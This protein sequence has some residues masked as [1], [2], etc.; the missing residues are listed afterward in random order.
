[1]RQATSKRM[2][3]AYGMLFAWWSIRRVGT[4]TSSNHCSGSFF[5]SPAVIAHS[6]V[7]EHCSF[8]GFETHYQGFGIFAAAE[9]AFGSVRRWGRDL[10]AEALIV[11]A[12]DGIANHHVGE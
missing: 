1:M 11:E 6:D 4:T 2:Q 8:G 3:T 12:G 7:H 10:E 5:L 9:T